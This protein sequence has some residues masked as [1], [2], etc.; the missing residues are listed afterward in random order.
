MGLMIP[1]GTATLIWCDGTDIHQGAPTAELVGD[2]AVS[3]A[4]KDAYFL[5]DCWLPAWEVEA[6]TEKETSVLSEALHEDLDCLSAIA[7]RAVQD[8][9]HPASRRIL[10]QA[11]SGSSPAQWALCDLAERLPTGDWPG[12]LREYVLDALKWGLPPCKPGRRRVNSRRDQVIAWVTL[13]LVKRYGL[14]AMRNPGTST[15]SACSIVQAA[16][17]LFEIKMTEKNVERIWSEADLADLSNQERDMT[18]WIQRTNPLT[19]ERASRQ[20][21]EGLE[22]Q[23]R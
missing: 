14:H 7:R 19:R 17:T 13:V 12:W 1:E 9:E 15:E 16:I 3:S 10:E 21:A 4:I 5:L 8:V 11:R 23:L 6:P 20:P 2:P 18:D 22:P